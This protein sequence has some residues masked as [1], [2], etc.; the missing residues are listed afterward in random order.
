MIQGQ[1]HTIK[2]NKTYFLTMTIINWIDV[3]TRKNHCDTVIQALNYCQKE[4]GL[5]IFAFCIMSNHIHM[6]V[7]VNET[8]ELKKCNKRF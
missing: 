3:F 2:E 7:N 4:K 8:H 5:N 6:L 1:K